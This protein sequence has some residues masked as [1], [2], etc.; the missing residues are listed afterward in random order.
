MKVVIAH[1]SQSV[2]A[3]LNLTVA[4]IVGKNKNTLYFQSAT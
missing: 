3:Q 2:N 1:V 4:V